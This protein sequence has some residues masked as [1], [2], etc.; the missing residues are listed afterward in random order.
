[1]ISMQLQ[2]K[3]I[4]VV[5][6]QNWGKM[7]LSKHHYA[8]TLARQGNLVYFLNPPKQGKIGRAGA[9]NIL[10]SNEKNLFLL[11]HTIGFPFIIKFHAIPIFHWFM[12]LH[13]R[14]VLRH[15]GKTIDIVWS[16]DQLNL[17]PFRFFDKNSLKIFQPV[18]EP[19]NKDALAAAS[20]CDI[21]L[22]V[23][24]G[25]LN[26]YKHLNKPSHLINHG[27]DENFLSD[28]IEKK[29]KTIHVGFSG[30]LLRR[31]IDRKIFLQIVKENPSIVFECWGSYKLQHTN[32]GGT[33]DSESDTFIQSLQQAGVI[34]HGPVTSCELATG[35]HRMD[36]FLICYDVQKDPSKGTNYH[37]IMEYLATGKVIISSNIITYKDDRDL[38]Q[39]VVER[40][41]NNELPGLFKKVI[42]NLHLY[43][44]QRLQQIRK[45]YAR[46]NT[47]SKQIEK[48]ERILQ[49]RLWPAMMFCEFLSIY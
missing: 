2:N 18:D 40:D 31:D 25:I 47:Y 42:Q 4:L 27:I 20:G 22:S 49:K 44:C 11:E 38:V 30:N 41:H 9:I 28:A 39:M 43:N 36:A 17:Y 14:K 45:D 34:L 13:I 15:I 16:F 8:I 33:E 46:S 26:K 32:I 3:V 24:N 48:I 1:M 5:S 19:G 35:L 23:T 7:F 12:K 29:N 37:K 10:P 21:I 6:P